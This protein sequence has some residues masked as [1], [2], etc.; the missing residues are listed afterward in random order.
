MSLQ[1]DPFEVSKR[2]FETDAAG[3]AQRR[4]RTHAVGTGAMVGGSAALGAGALRYAKTGGAKGAVL[5][6]AGAGGIVSGAMNRK[7]ARTAPDSQFGLSKG[8][9]ADQ[10][11]QV[12]ATANKRKKAADVAVFGGAGTALGGSLATSHYS[13]QR[14]RHAETFA[15]NLGDR[16][17]VAGEQS[18]RAHAKAIQG[19]RRGGKIA[20]AGAGAAVAGVAGN[21]YAA[22]KKDAKRRE[23]LGKADHKGVAVSIESDPFEVSKGFEN[24]LKQ[25]LA[26]QRV[27]GMKVSGKPGGATQIGSRTQSA[28]NRASAPGTRP[29]ARPGAVANNAAKDL[30]FFSS[31]PGKKFDSATGKK[32]GLFGKAAPS[33]PFEVAKQDSSSPSTGRLVAGGVFPGFHGAVAGK[34]GKKLEAAGHEVVPSLV[35]G[36]VLGPPGSIA[37]GMIGTSMAHKKGY[38]QPQ[39]K[40]AKKAKKKS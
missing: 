37:G 29:S 36:A 26:L 39:H 34:K 13:A 8:L 30:R 2:A 33:D 12:Q 32:K 5:S 6:A 40:K 35:G 28:L 16:D 20:V 25:G 18:A 19:V 4:R 17:Y 7:R 31:K 14:T 1:S 24:G 11:R 10:R 27:A 15:R 9:N 3:A 22:R 38:Y 23:L 21:V